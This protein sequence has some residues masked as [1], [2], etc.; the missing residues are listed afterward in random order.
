M[1]FRGSKMLATIPADLL[2]SLAADV[3]AY[4]RNPVT[5]GYEALKGRI[6]KEAKRHKVSFSTLF[7]EAHRRYSASLTS[8]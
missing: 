1:D 3:T 5:G 6:E 4:H 7:G 8:A 2:D